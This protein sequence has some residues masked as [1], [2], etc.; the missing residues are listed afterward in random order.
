MFI[1]YFNIFPKRFFQQ[2]MLNFFL[3]ANFLNLN[4]ILFIYF[5]Q[6]VLFLKKF[7][8]CFIFIYFNVSFFKDLI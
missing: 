8:V 5:I 7:L 3:F 4:F 1:I 2:H 6:Q